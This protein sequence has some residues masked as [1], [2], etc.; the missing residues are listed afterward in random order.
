MTSRRVDALRVVVVGAGGVG[1]YF[2]GALAHAGHDV[3]LFARGDH[4]GDPLRLAGAGV[5]RVDDA[6]E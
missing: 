4:L 3:T 2:G 5:E 1:G 6:S